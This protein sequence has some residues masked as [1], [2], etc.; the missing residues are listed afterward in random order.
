[1]DQA[2][3]GAQV[4]LQ[5]LIQLR[6]R[7]RSFTIDSQ[8]KVASATAGIH[9]SRFRGRGVDYQESRRYQPGDDIR[10]MDWRV[11][12]R[13]G[14]PHTKLY[15]EER[16][17]PVILMLDFGP[18]MYFGTRVRFKSVQAARAAALIAWAT[19]R[20]GDRIGAFFF[21]QGEHL[22]IRPT[23]G[24]RG[25]LRLIR[26]LVDWTSRTP[27]K[28]QTSEG[29]GE[30]LRRM[31]RVARPGSLVV[32][33]SD[34]YSLDDQCERHLTRLCEHTDV[35]ACMLVDPLELEVPPPARYG[36][37]DGRRRGL[38]DL[39]AKAGRSRYGQYFESHRQRV[40]NLMQRRRLPVFALRTDEDIAEALRQGLRGKRALARQRESA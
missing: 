22:E 23:G 32:I 10:N 38:L 31:R 12:A 40:R 16:E 13:S 14:K 33:L 37:S 4:S 2:L 36:I 29:M 11:T 6:L 21:D 39:N 27:E 34:F 15:Q 25:A 28:R 20:Y 26:Q 9:E 17:R 7:A 3:S 18:S 35:L 8:R 30:A 19:V 24:Q 5:E 1:M